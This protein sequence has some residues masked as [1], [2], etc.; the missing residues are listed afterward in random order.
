MCVCVCDV[1][2]Q[3]SVNKKKASID[4]PSWCHSNRTPYQYGNKYTFIN[5]FS[6]VSGCCVRNLECEE[7]GVSVPAAVSVPMQIEQ[8][9]GIG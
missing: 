3:F 1:P 9:F 2:S 7:W 6:N 4:L 8:H 5:H